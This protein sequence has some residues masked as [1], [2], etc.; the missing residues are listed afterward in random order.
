[1]MAV[2]SQR[3]HSGAPRNGEPGIH[4]GAPEVRDSGFRPLAGP[5]MTASLSAAAMLATGVAA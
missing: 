5:G 3:R 1:M 2:V 4:V